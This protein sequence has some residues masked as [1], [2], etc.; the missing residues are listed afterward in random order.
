[1]HINHNI[2][3]SHASRAHVLVVGLLIYLAVSSRDI[4]KY[5]AISKRQIIVK[6]SDAVSG[7]RNY[8]TGTCRDTKLQQT[9]QFG[10]RQMTTTQLTQK[11]TPN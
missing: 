6:S 11:R 5:N 10:R 7:D 4:V 2:A 9:A 1:M 8:T 3:F